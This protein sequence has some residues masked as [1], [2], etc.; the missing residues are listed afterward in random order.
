MNFRSIFSGAFISTFESPR[1]P[2]YSAQY[3][4]QRRTNRVIE[5]VR[6]AAVTFR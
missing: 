1:V 6:Y 3:S 4:G 5:E 2:S